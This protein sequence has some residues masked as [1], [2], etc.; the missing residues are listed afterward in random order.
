MSSPL[1]PTLSLKTLFFLVHPVLVPCVHSKYAQSH[2]YTHTC[3]TRSIFSSSILSLL[4]P[5]FFS[6]G[7][8]QCYSPYT[9][10]FVPVRPG[11]DGSLTPF[12]LLVWT[13][14]DDALSGSTLQSHIVA[15]VPWVDDDCEV[16]TTLSDRYPSACL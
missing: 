11:T 9:T 13:N 12:S 10:F 4:F 14:T 5:F 16:P 3:R 8:R 7:A 1:S 2:I 6:L 15:A